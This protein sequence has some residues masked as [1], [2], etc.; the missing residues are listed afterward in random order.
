MVT[1]LAATLAL[2]AGTA[3]ADGTSSAW[4]CNSFGSIFPESVATEQA[5]LAPATGNKPANFIQG[6]TSGE[7]E[8]T[9]DS[10]TVGYLSCTVPAGATAINDAA[11]AQMLADNDGWLYSASWFDSQTIVYPAYM[12]VA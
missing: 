10:V 8:V 1:A 6:A 2:L 3:R 4:L 7:V 5:D 11:G 12:A 9:S